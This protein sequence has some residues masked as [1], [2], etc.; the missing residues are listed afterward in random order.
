MMSLRHCKH[1]FHITS[2]IAVWQDKQVN[3]VWISVREENT[4]DR[5][6]A[7]TCILLWGVA[8]NAP[9][10]SQSIEKTA[11]TVTP[12]KEPIGIGLYGHH[13]SNTETVGVNQFVLLVTNCYSK[14]S[15]AV[16][17]SKTITL[18]IAS[19]FM[20]SWILPHGIPTP[21]FTDN[22]TFFVSI[23]FASVNTFLR[24]I[25]LTTTK[26]HMPTNEQIERFNSTMVTRLRPY[27]TE[28]HL[29]SGI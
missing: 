29:N 12:G 10:A 28:N 8:V 4:T 20:D 13:G 9:E 15:K 25:Y 23:C 16:F 19:L 26:Y 3:D 14:L 18:P 2:I 27:L 1:V 11:L 22:E 24:T 5:T 7:T 21:V 17:T 6:W